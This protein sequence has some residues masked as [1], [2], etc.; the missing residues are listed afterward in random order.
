MRFSFSLFIAHLYPPLLLWGIY[1]VL[2]AS[3]PWGSTRSHW[4]IVG[5]KYIY[6]GTHSSMSLTL[7]QWNDRPETFCGLLCCG[8]QVLMLGRPDDLW[9][10]KCV[11]S[12]SLPYKSGHEWKRG[13]CHDNAQRRAT[14][15]KVFGCIRWSRNRSENPRW[16]ST[17]SRK[18]FSVLWKSLGLYFL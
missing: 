5:D 17:D 8:K 13:W 1:L 7:S 18:S 14:S 9:V 16:E 11:A 3:W 10:C 15:E 6:N 2:W 4:K 12:V